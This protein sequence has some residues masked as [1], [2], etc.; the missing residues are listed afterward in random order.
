MTGSPAGSTWAGTYRFAAPHYVEATT[1]AEVQHAVAAGGAVRALGTRHSFNDLA[2]TTGTL[3]TVTGI[4]PDPVLDEAARTVTVGGG[5]RYGVLA[6][7]LEDR[8]WALHNLGSLPHISVA[9]AIATGTHGSGI[10]NR[11]LSA[12]VA[13]LEYVNHLGDLVS[14]RRGDADF[15]GMVVGLGA[16]GIVVRVTLEVQP[17]YQVR[18]DVYRDLPWGAVLDDL[19]AVLGAGYSVSLFDDWLGDTLDQAWVKSRIDA[20]GTVP[21]EWFGAARDPRSEGRLIDLASENL[22]VQ[23]GVPGAWLDR[24]PH[25]RLETTPSIG[26]EIQTEYFVDRAD[27]SAALRA[28]RALGPRIAPH[29]LVTELRTA[30]A[31]ELWL[32]P[33]Y[34]RDVLAIHFTFKNEPDAVAELVG[35]IQAALAPFGARP[36]WGKVTDFDAAAI[37][38]V[39][40]RAADARALFDALDPDAR[41]SNARLEFWGLRTPR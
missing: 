18:Q 13:G 27:G 16:F 4:G 23:G 8:G 35:P 7:W 6:R 9:G 12:A 1:I 22:T 41:F 14:T 39:H 3:I 11:V 17:S 24:L 26:D 28:I 31:D 20:S 38:R 5:I 32:S 40:P 29:L 21:D 25:F 37:A 2:D 19:D 34:Q 30:A 10:G 36:H 33:A 15:D